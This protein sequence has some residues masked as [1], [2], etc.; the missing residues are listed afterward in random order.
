MADQEHDKDIW[1]ESGEEDNVYERKLAEREWDRLQEDHV[2]GKE[3]N[4]QKGFDEGYKDGL[5]IGKAV[6]KLRGVVGTRIVFYEQ[7]LKNEEAANELRALFNEIDS[8]E[9][10]HIYSVDYFRKDGPKDKENYISPKDFQP[11]EQRNYPQKTMVMPCSELLARS[12]TTTATFRSRL[13]L[14]DLPVKQRISTKVIDDVRGIMRKV[15][16]PVVVV[17]TSKPEDPNYRR[18]ITVASFTSVC[19]NPEPLVSFCVRVPSRASQLLHSSG[20]MVVNM[21]SHEQVQQSTAFSSPDAD[22]FKDVPFFDDPITGLPV[23][24]GT[25][26][27]MHCEVFKV[28]QLGDH[29]MWIIKVLKVEEGV[30]GE[31]GLR[32]ESKPLL[33]YDRGYRSV[34]DQV[35]MKAFTENDGTL[36]TTKWTHRAHLRMAWNYIR[37]L[38]PDAAG[39]VIKQTIQSHFKKDTRKSQAYNET[40]TSFYIALV[41]AAVRSFKDY[42]ND[43]FAL[44]ERYPELLDPKTIETYYSP[45]R[46]HTE[47]AKHE[48]VEPDLRPLPKKL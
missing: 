43:F 20:S 35:F 6:G 23:L 1:A 25:V 9:V 48:F 42:E 44:V 13:S 38:G 5:S 7:L 16:Q 22:Q 32:E 33:Y 40:I 30:G 39:P 37:E 29:E 28:V 3:V 21:L 24:M 41:S 47:K 2:E 34:G 27:A 14:I 8:V 15:P 36:N 46:L 31:H 17:T 10:N 45:E 11:K 26:G 12:A 4:M 19:L 18:G